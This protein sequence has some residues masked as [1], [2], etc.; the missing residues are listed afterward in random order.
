MSIE[1][2]KLEADGQFDEI[3]GKDCA[4]VH[5]EKMSDS[6]WCLIFSDK[7]GREVNVH[8]GSKSSRT[9]YGFIYEDTGAEGGGRL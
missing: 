3:V 6:E 7:D 1:I 2:R 8:L 4:C 5:L 9:A